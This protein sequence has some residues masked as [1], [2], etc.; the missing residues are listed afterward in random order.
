M[1][2]TI[3]S[4][5]DRLNVISCTVYCTVK[6]QVYIYFITNKYFKV[7]FIAEGI[8]M[9][10]CV[11]MTEV[12]HLIV[13]Y[14][15]PECVWAEFLCTCTHSCA[16][17]KVRHNASCGHPHRERMCNSDCSSGEPGIRFPV[18]VF[19]LASLSVATHLT[20]YHSEGRITLEHAGQQSP[21][22]LPFLPLPS[23]PTEPLSPE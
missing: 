3:D 12:S 22:L 14:L 6:C 2:H 17:L 16:E 21:T 11:P 10:R 15:P 9:L 8:M 5:I 20:D 23:P 1:K 19:G 7:I 13:P 18:S 4:I